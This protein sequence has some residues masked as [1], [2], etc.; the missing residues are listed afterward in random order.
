[1]LEKPN[2]LLNVVGRAVAPLYAFIIDVQKRVKLLE[3]GAQPKY[4][5]IS[6]IKFSDQGYTIPAR[7]VG[8]AA[9]ISFSL[10]EFSCNK[11][12]LHEFSTED[13]VYI[14]DCLH[15]YLGSKKI[16]IKQF[17]FEKNE[18]I[19][20]YGKNEKTVHLDDFSTYNDDECHFSM[21]AGDDAAR[22]ALFIRDAT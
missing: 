20:A 2:S 15:E 4:K 8:K 22:L 19:L 10:E 3:D 21:M 6:P 5:L 12:L 7:I 14:N 18:L 11:E 17:D 9:P 1:M 13:A 16:S